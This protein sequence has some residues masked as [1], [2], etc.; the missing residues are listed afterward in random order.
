MIVGSAD[1]SVAPVEILVWMT[2]QGGYT[3]EKALG[4]STE[5]AVINGGLYDKYRRSKL[6]W[7]VPR[8]GM[9]NYGGDLFLFLND[10]LTSSDISI[11]DYVHKVQAVTEII[12]AN[13][14][15]FTVSNFS[16]Q[17]L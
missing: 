6:V 13:D 1:P 9:F 2:G 7:Y 5:Y 12:T 14:A 17:I 10:S 3:P 4:K 16:A 15:R 11:D 8:M